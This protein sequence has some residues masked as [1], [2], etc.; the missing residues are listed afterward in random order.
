[1]ILFQN[2]PAENFCDYLI[3]FAS[4]PSANVYTLQMQGVGF[5]VETSTPLQKDVRGQLSSHYSILSDPTPS[6]QLALVSSSSFNFSCSKSL[7]FKRLQDVE[8]A[9]LE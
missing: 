4:F 5:L 6:V 8:R 2:F 7:R 3:G 9:R 1:M